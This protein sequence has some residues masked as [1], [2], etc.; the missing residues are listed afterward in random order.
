MVFTEVCGGGM[1][2]AGGLGSDF[3]GVMWVLWAGYL[4]GEWRGGLGSWV[5]RWE[6]EDGGGVVRESLEG[7]RRVKVC[8]I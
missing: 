2:F 6:H 4:V 1:K 3:S 5:D 7:W 8:R